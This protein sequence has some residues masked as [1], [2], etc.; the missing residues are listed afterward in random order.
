MSTTSA[1]Y[2]GLGRRT[3]S[4]DAAGLTLTSSYNALDQVTSV[5][6]PAVG[7]AAATSIQYGYDSANS[8]LLD[9][10]I[11]RAGNT[12]TYQYDARLLKTQETASNGAVTQY[13]YDPL[14]RLFQQTDALNETTLYSYDQFDQL[15]QTVYPDSTNQTPREATTT[16]DAWGKVLTQSGTGQYP[17]TYAYDAAGNRENGDRHGDR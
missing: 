2:D 15:T 12:T 8:Q 4:T 5:G 3:S 16:Y 7:S 9:S 14:G 13:V 1:S 11:D 6:Y 10:M 17:V